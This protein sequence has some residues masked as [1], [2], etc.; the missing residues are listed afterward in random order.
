MRYWKQISREI[1]KKGVVK[2]AHYV[3]ERGE[4]TIFIDGKL[5]VHNYDRETNVRQANQHIE[6]GAAKYA[7]KGADPFGGMYGPDSIQ[8]LMGIKYSLLAKNYSVITRR[9]W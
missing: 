7:E 2:C 6:I 4:Y 9:P 3:L 1:S 5:K 8:L